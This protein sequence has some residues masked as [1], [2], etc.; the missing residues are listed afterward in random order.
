MFT[1]HQKH[2]SVLIQRRLGY[3]YI[4][5]FM[6]DEIIDQDEINKQIFYFYQSL[7]SKKFQFQTHN[8]DAFR[9]HTITKTH[10]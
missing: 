9:K 3:F 10:Q 5:N 7:F 2:V 1:F 4:S 8:R 6:Q